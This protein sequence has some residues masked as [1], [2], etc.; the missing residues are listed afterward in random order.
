MLSPRRPVPH[1]F[2]LYLY[3]PL[4]LGLCCLSRWFKSPPHH[5]P[6]RGPGASDTEAASVPVAGPEYELRAVILRST[7]AM[8][9]GA[10]GHYGAL[11]RTDEQ[12]E[13]GAGARRASEEEEM[14][15]EGEREEEG[16]WVLMDDGESRRVSGAEL[17]AILA[18][19]HRQRH[20]Q[21]QRQ[22]QRQTHRRD[23][24]RVSVS[25]CVSGCVSESESDSDSES[26]SSARGDSERERGRERGKSESQG[27]DGCE[28]SRKRSGASAGGEE[29]GEASRVAVL[30]FY[31]RIA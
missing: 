10:H 4:I 28:S 27:R 14:E 8:G 30:A 24:D 6:G 21:R 19:G 2:T 16:E 25:G 18:L 5:G 26:G 20:S 9:R 13:E 1:A 31:C 29:A 3:W 7:M 17:Q 15:V 23:A 22:R 12:R 11:C